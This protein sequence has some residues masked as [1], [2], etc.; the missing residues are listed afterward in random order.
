MKRIPGIIV[1]LILILTSCKTDDTNQNIKAV[2]LNLRYDNP[3]DSIN[4]WTNR[5]KT[6]IDFF[7]T[8]QPDLIG[9]QEVL[10]HQYEVLDSALAEYGS[11]GVGRDDGM[12]G[13]EMNPVFYR[14]DRFE[15]IESSTFWLSATPQTAGSKGWGASLPRIVTWA[16]LKDLNSGREFYFFNTHFAHDSD[17]A[18]LMSAGILREKVLE[19]AGDKAFIVTGDFNMSPEAPGYAVITAKTEGRTAIN[20]SYLL[21]ETA[22]EGP[23]FTYNAF[24]DRPGDSRIDFLFVPEGTAVYAH[25][26]FSIKNNGVFISDHWPVEA[27]VSFK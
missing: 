14:K 18:R 8:E 13:G 11:Q 25:K 10:W 15:L 9:M 21:S 4:A 2:T 24:S 6:V 27:V 17:S 3:R 22:P 7:R 1:A 19:I 20:D 23:V 5:I 26:T 16:R 12:K